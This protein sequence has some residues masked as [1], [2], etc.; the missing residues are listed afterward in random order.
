MSNTPIPNN[1]SQV[2]ILS[3]D[4]ADGLHLLE[5]AIGVK[6][7]TEAALRLDMATASTDSGIYDAAKTNK[8]TLSAN[9]R[10]ADSNARAFIKAARAVLAQRFGEHWGQ[11]WQAT[12]WPDS[13]TAVPGNQEKRARL[14]ATLQIYF[15]ANP[16]HENAPLEITAAKAG[17]LFTAISNARDAWHQGIMTT[18]QKRATRDASMDKLRVRMRGLISEL[19]QLLDPLDPR[20]DAFGLDQPGAPDLPE[21]PENLIVTTDGPGVLLADWPDSRRANYYRI[22][23]QV[24]DVDTE[25]RH[26]LNRDTSD[27]RIT[28]LPT[29]KTVKLRVTAVNET[30]ES[31]PSEEKETV[32]V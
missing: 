7:N 27:V 6:Q 20:W 29:G 13:C 11:S 3:E 16:T 25:F 30:G 2:F 12:G 8:K 31:L 24:M 18:G 28:S 23:I 32:V 17:A 14:C 10:I 9:I 21:V 22:Y 15:T 26:L 4:M 5:T 19:N 1:N